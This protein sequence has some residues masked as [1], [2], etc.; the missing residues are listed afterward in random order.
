MTNL[1][2]ATARGT[3]TRRALAHL[4]RPGPVAIAVLIVL[5]CLTQLAFATGGTGP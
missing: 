4:T 1:P 2:L 3:I 5:L